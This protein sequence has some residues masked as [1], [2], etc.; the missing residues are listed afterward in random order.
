MLVFISY[1]VILTQTFGK[2]TVTIISSILKSPV[3]S[4]SYHSRQHCLMVYSYGYMYMYTFLKLLTF[5]S[6]D[7]CMAIYSVNIII[8]IQ[9]LTITL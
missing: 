1:V 3:I 5:Y 2:T 6:Y 8:M 9:K 4:L 7:H